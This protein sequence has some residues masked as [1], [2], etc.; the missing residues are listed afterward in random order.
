MYSFQMLENHYIFSLKSSLW[1]T[2]QLY[3]NWFHWWR[4]DDWNRYF[5]WLKCLSLR[6]CS[7][8]SHKSRLNLHYFLCHRLLS[9]LSL[10]IVWDFCADIWIMSSTSFTRMKEEKHLTVVEKKTFMLILR[11][12]LIHH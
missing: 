3:F 7:N 9:C 6:F 8:L 4:L 5:S 11:S 12:F 2:I 10:M 1:S